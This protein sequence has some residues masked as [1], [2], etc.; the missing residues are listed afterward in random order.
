MK[1]II[2]M[3]C[4]VTFLF[5]GNA[6]Y[7]KSQKDKL[8]PVK[9]AIDKHKKELEDITKMWS[10]SHFTLE[11]LLIRTRLKIKKEVN[12]NNLL[13]ASKMKFEYRGFEVKLVQGRYSIGYKFFDS[14]SQLINWIDQRI[15]VK[16]DFI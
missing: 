1:F 3:F 2:L 8:N 12:L 13:G 5:A 15:A 10:S 16:P 11:L 4:L 14:L 7:I 9:D 6:I